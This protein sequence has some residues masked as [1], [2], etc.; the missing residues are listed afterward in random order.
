MHKIV[1]SYL[2][3]LVLAV[4]GA[5]APQQA[6]IKG[7]VNGLQ[8][9]GTKLPL[10]GAQVNIKGSALMATSM[11]NA[12]TDEEGRFTL[13]NLPPGDYVLTV[14]VPGFE[15]YTK[16][17]K[18]LAGSV[19]EFEIDLKLSAVSDV[20]EVQA[21]ND[22]ISRTDT[23]SPQELKEK[24]LKD[25][26]LVNERFQDALPLLPGVVRGPDGLLN[27][28][29]ARSSQSGLLVNST[30]VTDPVTGDFALS[31]PIEAIESVSVLSSPYSAEYGK[32][33]GAVTAIGTRAGGDEWRYL[34]TNFFPRF[35]RRE[36]PNTGKSKVVGIESF[37]PRFIIT[38]PIVKKKLTIS[39]SFEYRFIRTRV[40]S[41]PD[42]SNDTKLETFDS[43][44]QLDYNLSD[45]NHLTVILS[46]FPQNLSFINLN[47][48]N[49]ME[50]TPN[51]RQRGF[52][53]SAAD[54]MAF[55]NGSLLE[56]SFGIKRFNAFVFPQDNNPMNVAPERNTGNF[57]NRQD[58]FTNRYEGIMVYNLPI[59]RGFGDHAIKVGANISRDTFDGNDS[60]NSIRVVRADGTLSQLI[61]FVGAGKI[62]RNKLEYTGF[63]QDKVSLT[64]SI[65]LD[66]GLRYDHDDLASE[67]NFAPRFG[68]VIAPF[69][70]GRTVFRGGIGLFYDKV[71]L[72][73]GTFEQLQSRRVTSFADDGVTVIDGPSTF[74][75]RYAAQ[76][77]T[78]YSVSGTFE[79]DRQIVKGLFFRFGFQQREGRDEFIVEPVT[80]PSGTRMLLSNGGRSRY[81]EF[82]FTT[83]YKFKDA[84]EVTFSYAR[85]RATGDLNDFNTYFGNFRTPIIRANE[86]S[87]LP[88]DAPNRFL[89]FGNFSLPFDITAS[90]VIDARTGFPF[91]RLD[92]DQ[93]FI[94]PRNRDFRFPR[95][96]SVDLQ[97][98]KRF[99][100]PFLGKKYGT[101]V[102]VKIFNITNHFNPRDV[103]ANIDSLTFGKF[104]NS[105][106][107]TFRGKFEFD[108]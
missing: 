65:V 75:N 81:R 98:K 7:Q 35:R 32:F 41:L 89:V 2:L 80:E 19:G 56:L 88:F 52:F 86:H 34:F 39:Q 45:R 67:E 57:F 59:L 36:D 93:N 63:I 5:A 9:D 64:P 42:L 106:G 104:S 99:M 43:F 15:T 13:L 100:I 71:S 91:S 49:A 79:V 48:F 12:I 62:D 97:V 50:V 38:G 23:S 77:H 22:E 26:P 18:L 27:I 68:F 37:T 85:S 51:F 6:K 108:F 74:F 21:N 60:N 69:K 105:I 53:I 11:I 96:V 66:L 76:L 25:A 4:L 10:A 102:G 58:R 101:S 46:F 3:I 73:V 90:P 20:V 14:E 17:Y 44:T 61:D 31:L 92:E 83:R 8:A 84:N 55:N 28:K 70:D 29:G 87:R 94:G 78:P 30:N 95:F 103:Q 107:R 72:G 54:R 40:P 33:T 16:G 82:Q 1:N 47:T 24:A